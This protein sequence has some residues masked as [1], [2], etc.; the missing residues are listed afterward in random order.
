MENGEMDKMKKIR[1][2][3]LV[4]AL[5]VSSGCAVF[6]RGQKEDPEVLFIRERVNLTKEWLSAGNSIVSQTGNPKAK[7]IMSFLW[8]RG[9]I[10][11]P[12]KEKDPFYY[13]VLK[14]IVPPKERIVFIVTKKEDKNI[15]PYF[16]I[17]WSVN[18]DAFY[19]FR[20]DFLL[21]KDLHDTSKKWV[22]ITLMR[23][24]HHVL[25]FHQ[26][27]YDWTDFRKFCE[28]EIEARIFQ[29][30]IMEKVGGRR[31]KKY[32]EE[33]VWWLKKEGYKEGEDYPFWTQYDDELNQIFGSARSEWEK[34]VRVHGIWLHAFFKLFDEM[35]NARE[36]K[37]IFIQ[38]VYDL[39]FVLSKE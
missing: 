19:D 36:H 3:T 33:K 29:H 35:S 11:I 5:C 28:R 8:N 15:H 20:N 31:Y 23:V 37:I 7:E 26:S 2:Y 21:G 27:P 34:R 39:D 1:M 9:I 24:G 38:T 13:V 32:V 14:N 6:S 16:R 12:K 22:G 17:V 4:V 25:S 18:F 30:E 10:G